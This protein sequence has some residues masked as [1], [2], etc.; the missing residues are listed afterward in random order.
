MVYSSDRSE[1]TVVGLEF[2][3]LRVGRYAD[4]RRGGSTSGTLM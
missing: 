3:G 4:R 2:Q 1:D